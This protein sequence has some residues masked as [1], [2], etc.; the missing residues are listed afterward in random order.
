MR[1]SCWAALQPPASAVNAVEKL[2]CSGEGGC[3]CEH[4]LVIRQHGGQRQ[5]W[6]LHRCRGLFVLQSA[7]Q[8]AVPAPEWSGHT[9]QAPKER[10][11][12]GHALLVLELLLHLLLGIYGLH[13]HKRRAML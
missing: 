1:A 4:T 13:V 2:R 5:F 9:F 11:L 7:P 12:D 8:G 3:S 10:V 6:C